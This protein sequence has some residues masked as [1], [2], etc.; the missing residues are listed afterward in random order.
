[1]GEVFLAED[2][3][4]RRSVAI[5]LLPPEVDDEHAVRRLIREARSAAALDHPNICAIHEIG[6]DAGRPFIV[7]QYIEGE[8]LATRMKRGRIEVG[9]ALGLAVQVTDA[10]A[11]A[12]RRGIIHRDIKPHNIMLTARGQAKVLDFGLA[13]P[14]AGPAGNETGDPTAT[15]LTSPGV[16]AGTV[17]YMSPEQARGET[18]DGRS[19]IFSLGVVLYEML[20]GRQP[21]AAP[22]AAETLSAILTRDPGS[23][24]LDPAAVPRDLERIVAKALRKDREERYQD[25]RDLHLDLK[26]AKAELGLKDARSDDAPLPRPPAASRHRVRHGALAVASLAVVAT[27]GVI[28]AHHAK[29]AWAAASVARVAEL[30][31]AEDY[32]AAY[33]LASRIRSYRPDDR[34]LERLLTVVSDDLSVSSE[35]PGASVSV[36]RFS[37]SGAS[38]AQ[39]LGRTPISHH[40][41]AR[42]DYVLRLEL[43]GHEPFERSI[44]SAIARSEFRLE[45]SP[46][47]QVEV[48]LLETGSVPPRMTPIPGGRYKLVGYGQPTQAAA[49]LGDYFIDR[50]EVSNR[51]YQRFVSTGGYRNRD[52]WRH[53]FVDGVR[54]LGWDEA[55]R[56]LVDRTGLPGPRGWSGGSPPEGTLDHPVTGVTWYEAAAYAAH[57]GK[58]L[59]TVYQWEKAARDGAWV[60]GSERVM[61]WGIAHGNDLKGR[62]N[63]EGSGTVPVD[64]LEF[65]MS[66]YGCFNMA[67]NVTEWLLNE[68]PDGFLSSGGCWADPSYIFGEF[69]TLPGLHSS[70]RVGFRCAL[71]APGVEGDQG[72]QKIQTRD[73]APVYPRSSDADFRAWL[74]HYRYDKTPL[75]ARV[76]ETRDT[77]DWKLEKVTF[78]GAGGERTY[79]YLY[80]PKSAQP[81]FQVI[82]FIPPSPAYEGQAPNWFVESGRAAGHIK[83][84]RAIFIVAL[85]GYVGR[86]HA[87]GDK[88][89][90]R[91]TVAYRDHEIRD[92]TD[93]RRGLDYLETRREI[94]PSRLALMNASIARQVIV[95]SAVEPRYRA[96]V[97]MAAGL[98]PEQQG[99]IAQANPVF[100]APHIKPPK[101]MLNGRWDE[102]FAFKTEAEP[103]FKLLSEPKRLELYDG[104]HVPPVEIAVPVINR[105][106]DETLGP[107]RRD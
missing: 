12:H 50:Y 91:D 43:A 1:M 82:Q 31:K 87:G 53:P 75:E 64:A 92:A 68:A 9:E 30:A 85:R 52:Y 3:V 73:L 8:T 27:A 100:F 57:L 81:P 23:L 99:Y 97:L 101:L 15:A 94:D 39:L 58:R 40:P 71:T 83:A 14:V 102:D 18:L 41:L 22:S 20:S 49:L 65:G 106:L 44:S 47:I 2:E 70:E 105:F 98:Y 67:G 24:G 79:A 74:S 51:D 42:G 38:P 19:D 16:V 34:E 35:P 95:F 28:Y 36:R 86:E 7:M 4:L 6:S 77:P 29:T 103:L 45:L 89:L 17:P 32:A 46:A 76:E 107:V 84:G 21:F 11:E 62:A 63:F 90:E 104:G 96:V 78:E 54:T 26:A 33:D 13:K 60:L 69:G 59:P 66:P 56:K 72:G 61:P 55:L 37:A 80:L 25:V 88:R 93:L 48:R 5:K 10:L